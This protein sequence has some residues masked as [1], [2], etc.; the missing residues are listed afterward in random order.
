MKKI[1]FPQTIKKFPG[2][3]EGREMKE[4]GRMMGAEDSASR[5]SV[6]LQNPGVGASEHPWDGRAGGASDRLEAWPGS[7]G[8][9]ML[10]RAGQVILHG[11]DEGRLSLGAPVAGSVA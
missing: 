3:K 2:A 11:Q 9:R 10:G 7:S 6:S 8:K 1:A 4:G 5:D